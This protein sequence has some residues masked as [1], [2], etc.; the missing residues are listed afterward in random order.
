MDQKAEGKRCRF[1]ASLQKT[2]WFCDSSYDKVIGSD[3]YQHS[4][5]AAVCLSQSVV[6]QQ[7]PSLMPCRGPYEGH[8]L[9]RGTYCIYLL[10]YILSVHICGVLSWLAYNRITMIS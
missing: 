3:L 8:T 6:F 1:V 7:Y 10:L 5:R 9:G 4:L 2:R